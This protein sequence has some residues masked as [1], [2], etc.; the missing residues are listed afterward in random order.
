M[1]A[2][3]ARRAAQAFN[4]SGKQLTDILDSVKDAALQ[5]KY[6]TWYYKPIAKETRAKLID[7]GYSIGD[8]SFDRN[9]HLT[10]IIWKP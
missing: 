4:E 6:E 7:L 8:T 5:G 10:K 2:S 1:N 9:E 3:E